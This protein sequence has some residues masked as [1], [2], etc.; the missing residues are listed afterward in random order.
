M[1]QSSQPNQE[2]DRFSSAIPIPC[3]QK[4][5]IAFVVP[6]FLAWQ[7]E[8]NEGFSD[9]SSQLNRYKISPDN[10]RIVWPALGSPLLEISTLE[11]DHHPT[12]KRVEVFRG[13]NE[14]VREALNLARKDSYFIAATKIITIGNVEVKIPEGEVSFFGFDIKLPKLELSSLTPTEN[15][16]AIVFFNKGS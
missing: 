3:P 16:I 9:P 4:D 14:D 13:Y 12:A 6:R 2:P 8:L 11:A 5:Q 7:N 15:H 1:F 10:I